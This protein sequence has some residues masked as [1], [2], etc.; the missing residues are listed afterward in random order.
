MSPYVRRH[1]GSWKRTGLHIRRK[2]EGTMDAANTIMSS[3]IV[4][5]AIIAVVVIVGLT[6]SLIV[7][8]LRNI[9]EIDGQTPQWP[10]SWPE[11]P[12]NLPQQQV[13]VPQQR[14]SLPQSQS[15]SQ[16]QA[17]ADQPH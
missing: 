10:V 4:M 5:I 7:L 12:V 1:R 8:T 17:Q 16:S 11:P 14:A 9:R 15:Q 6:A 2:P 3:N 13:D